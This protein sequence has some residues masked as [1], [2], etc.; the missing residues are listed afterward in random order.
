MTSTYIETFIYVH[1]HTCSMLID[2]L[3]YDMYCRVNI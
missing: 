2:L 3:C 1:V